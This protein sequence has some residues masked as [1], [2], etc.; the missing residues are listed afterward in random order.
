MW[1]TDESAAV[2]RI[3]GPGQAVAM[4]RIPVPIG[5]LSVSG[6]GARAAYWWREYRGD[7]WLYRVVTQ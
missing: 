6:D 7:A 3:R 4:G 1:A 2:W 5:G